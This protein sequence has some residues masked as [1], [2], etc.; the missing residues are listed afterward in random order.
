MGISS[1]YTSMKC[2]CGKTLMWL[3]ATN[4]ATF[5]LLHI[6]ALVSHQV[7]KPWLVQ[8]CLEQIM[9]S[10]GWHGLLYKPWSLATYMFTQYEFLH[11]LMNMLA[12][13]VF[14][15]QMIDSHRRLLTAYLI[16]GVA[17][18]I[19][20]AAAQQIGSEPTV[21]AGASASIAAVMTAVTTLS[22]DRPLY[23]A[24]VGEVRLIYITLAVVAFMV[25]CNL[26]APIATHAAHFGGLLA[27]VTLGVIWHRRDVTSVVGQSPK[28]KACDLSLDELLDKMRKSGFNSLTSRERARLFDLSKNIG[29][30]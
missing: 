22:P 20:A 30:R 11:L 25:L 18:G 14:A 27:G 4:V 7:G 8:T 16:G 12:L 5:L 1:I 13:W 15:M 10:G 6:V 2:R 23:L 28:T 9:V 17:G 3:L 21:V 29:K 26:D 24:L 19:C